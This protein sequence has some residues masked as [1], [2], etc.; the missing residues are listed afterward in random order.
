MKKTTH[1]LCDRKRDLAAVS[2]RFANSLKI[3]IRA[4]NIG[5]R[6][7]VNRRQMRGSSYDGNATS[8]QSDN[9]V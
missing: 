5:F 1:S 4:Q 7:S 3:A 2:E 9:L 6:R 8:T